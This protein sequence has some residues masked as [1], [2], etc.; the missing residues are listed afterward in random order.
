VELALA[1]PFC[2]R[3][4]FGINAAGSAATAEQISK[5]WRNLKNDPSLAARG[6]QAC[7]TLT[8]LELSDAAIDSLLLER[9]TSNENLLKRHPWFAD[10]ENW[11][12]DAQLGLLSMAWAMGAA[13]PEN[14][15]VFR[16]ACRRLDF[17]TAAAECK[18]DETG[19]P[20]LIPRNR[21]NAM[22]F[23]NAAIV[24]E[25]GPG[26]GFDSANLYYPGALT[27]Q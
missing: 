7:E 17:K 24:L 14:F 25:R 1:L 5:E 6:Y 10:F 19:N 23:S 8:Q 16:A 4:Q 2:F 12:A 27:T 11:P 20:G 22:L 21:A 26:D 3:S 15:P 13:G 18:M 9:L